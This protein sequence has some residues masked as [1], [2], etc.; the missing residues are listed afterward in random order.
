MQHEGVL[1]PKLGIKLMPPAM[2][3]WILNHW[4]AREI[5]Q[6]AFLICT[7]SSLGLRLHSRHHNFV[8]GYNDKS[9]L[10]ICPNLVVKT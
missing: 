1:V 3:V 5:A 7:Y 8:A 6:V 2:E 9:D 4:T 10:P